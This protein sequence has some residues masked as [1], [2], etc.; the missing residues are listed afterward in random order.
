MD[1]SSISG[2]VV[3]Q[4][5]QPGRPIAEKLLGGDIL[6]SYFELT[7]DGKG[8]SIGL[9]SLDQIDSIKQVLLRNGRVQLTIHRPSNNGSLSII[10]TEL[11]VDLVAQDLTQTVTVM[12]TERTT[13]NYIVA[14]PYTESRTQTYTVGA[15]P[16]PDGIVKT[17]VYYATNRRLQG[18]QYSG[19]RISDSSAVNY[20]ICFVTIPPDHRMG[21]LEGPKWSRLEL[22][23]NPEKHVV[24]QSVNQVG[25]R[26]VFDS[27][28][29]Q[30]A[31]HPD[32]KRRMLVFVHGYNVTFADA[33]RRSAQ[34]HYDLNF[35]GLSSFFSWPS[36]GNVQSYVSDATDIE[37][38]TFHL[39]QFLMKLN[40]S[41]DV[42]EIFII[43]HSMGNRGTTAALKQMAV[44]DQGRKIKEVV[45]AAPD[46]DS[47]LFDRDFAKVLCDYYPRLTVYASA[48]DKALWGSNF[49]NQ[50]PRV[51]EI[52]NSVPTILSRANLDIIDASN[53]ETSF[54][55]HSY[56]ADGNSVIS[57][58]FQLIRNQNA[59]GARTNLLTQRSGANGIFWAFRR[60]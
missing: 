16:E 26:G 6:V 55:S 58:I 56:Y 4:S 7:A 9:T 42:D 21:Q 12:R 18:G 33:A 2:Q 31:E 36:N 22:R 1:L 43:A 10:Y 28:R 51:G 11:M 14:V 39:E 23:P 32:N 48:N 5:V 24:L 49:R 54:L 17:A 34:I 27:I 50:T 25:E 30:F 35:P 13:T 38:S 29:Q 57:D 15:E 47:S 60:Q 3:V 44:N 8:K 45:L 40:Q 53:V 37:W 19:E 52:R 20:G 59:P 46:V 41:G